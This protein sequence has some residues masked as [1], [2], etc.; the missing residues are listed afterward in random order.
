MV[1]WAVLL[2]TATVASAAVPRTNRIVGGEPTTVETYPSIVQLDF[3]GTWTGAWSQSC[4]ATIITPKTA[5]SA[6]HCTENV[7]TSSRR[8]RA[9]SSNRNSGGIIINLEYYRNHPEYRQ[10]T[11]YDADICILVLAQ[12]L[13]FT[14]AIQQAPINA[15]GSE[16]PD[17]SA[18][19]HAGWG[20]TSSGGSS[21]SILRDVTIYTINNSVC[22]NRYR[23]GVTQNMICAGILDV[24]GKDACQGDSGGPLYYNKILVGVV[25]WGRGCADAYYPGV[26]TKVSSYSDWIRNNAV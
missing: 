8:I 3:L 22:A 20:T 14:P 16:L 4:A 7:S 6:A 23:T 9:G 2:L 13:S 17:G 11:R 19:I 10:Q 12:S 15:Q 21:S 1:T 5:V 26:S 25:S 24:G 18:V